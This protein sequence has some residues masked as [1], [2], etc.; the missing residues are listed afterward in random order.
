MT[1]IRDPSNASKSL[2]A[3]A[4]R[5]AAAASRPVAKIR[6][7]DAD[8]VLEIIGGGTFGFS[9]TAAPDT[10]SANG[11]SSSPIQVT[12]A[13]ATVTVTG[14]RAPYTYLWTAPDPNWEA[15]DPTSRIS[16]FSSGALDPGDTSE[17][18]FTCTVT[19][20][21]GATTDS[22]AVHVHGRN[23]GGML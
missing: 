10:F 12:T 5:D 1:A 7:R 15:T 23:R 2:K 11:S 20:A 17:T 21:D 4:L 16:A 19:D 18:D 8:N 14:G 9:A 22:N 6:I 13:V 3:V